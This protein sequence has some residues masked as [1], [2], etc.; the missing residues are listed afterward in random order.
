MRRLTDRKTGRL[1]ALLL[2]L[3]PAAAQVGAT[4]AQAQA[5]PGRPA[6]DYIIEYDSIHHPV[7]SRLGMVVSQNDVASRVGSEILARGGNAVDAAV[8]T[9]FALAVTLPRAGNIGGGGFMLVHLAREKRTV[10][11]EYYDEAPAALR[12]DTLR[13]ADGKLDPLKRYS[14][15]GV[16]V[17]GTPLGLYEAHQRYGKLPW[18]M[19]L[20]PAIELAKRGMVVTDD[21]SNILERQRGQIGRDAEARQLFLPGG[22]APLPD[23]ILKQQDLAWSLEQLRDH[24]AN[25]FYRGAIARRLVA[26]VQAGGGL[27]TLDDLARYRVR[28]SEPLWGSYR[29]RRIA[30]MPEP[31]GGIFLAELMNLLEQFDLAAMGQN[32]ADSLHIIAEASKLVF[33]DRARFAGGY[34]G[35]APP[36]G[37]ADKGYAAQRAKAIAM[38]RSL[39]PD[40][41]S[42]GN[43]FGEESRDTTHIS[44][45]DA[46]GNAV[47]N[48]FTL[49][50]DFGA[51][52]VAPGTGFL[53][54]DALANFAW[55]GPHASASPN[56][57]APRRRAVSTIS[58]VMVFDQDRPWIVSGT[59]GGTRIFSAMAQLLS[60][61]ID[62][63]LNVA[64]ATA[65]PRVFQGTADSPLEF[66]PGFPRDMLTLLR[67]RGHVATD[68]ATMGSTQTILIEPNRL[69]GAAD[70]RRPDAAAIP[71]LPCVEA[72]RI[73]NCA[74][75]R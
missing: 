45:V 34:P 4:P 36:R 40:A 51:K 70:T 62:H 59:P 71:A 29:G 20:E 19:L 48:T 75:R 43:P 61:I 22:A 58:P 13:G 54:N 74:R 30:Y 50:S 16:G 21:L 68:T 72:R 47:S 44:V 53:L 24:G 15:R 60:N 3:A 9:G 32:S 67:Q 49:G 35:Y 33:A 1:A 55:S 73:T 66:E 57:P 39:G 56:A 69:L 23:T 46:D 37:L 41:V 38:A 5:A 12:S 10:A 11:I 64:E 65:R 6:Q 2:L 17:P 25:A 8:A 7:I 27:I 63:R 26:G 18:R 31:S 14:F 52:V 42:A 28:E